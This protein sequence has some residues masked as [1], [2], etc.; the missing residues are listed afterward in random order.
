[1]GVII[2][3]A[4]VFVILQYNSFEVPVSSKL[5]NILCLKKTELTLLNNKYVIQGEGC[6]HTEVGQGRT[7]LGSWT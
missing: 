2:C 1:M 7:F 6:P 4:K 5:P 3:F